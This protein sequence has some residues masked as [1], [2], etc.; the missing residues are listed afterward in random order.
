MDCAHARG[1]LAEHAVGVLP[2]KD[3]RGLERHLE[4]CA[5]CRRETRELLEGAEAAAVAASADPPPHLEDRTVEVIRAAGRRRR[6]RSAMAVALVAALLAVA[7]GSWGAVMAGRAQR[8]ENA[9]EI[10]REEAA[11]AARE[12]GLLVDEVGEGTVREAVLTARGED[13]VGGRALLYDAGSGGA[14]NWILVFVGGLPADGER[15]R[16]QAIG[17]DDPL[18]IGPLWPS[19]QGR[20][21]AYRLF[22]GSAERYEELVVVDEEGA[23]VL[24]GEFRSR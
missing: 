19:S 3:R 16:A 7:L 13:T 11:D 18:P 20:V 12:F 5:G 1:L 22:G 23:P 17:G 14:A 8:L 2:G 4:W 15:Y 6:P 21:A 10:A 24:R 9:A